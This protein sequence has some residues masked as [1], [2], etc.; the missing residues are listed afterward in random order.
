[1][2]QAAHRKLHQGSPFSRPNFQPP[3]RDLP[4]L[5]EAT[6]GEGEEEEE[7]EEE[8]WLRS[9]QRA[10]LALSRYLGL[11]LEA[12]RDLNPSQASLLDELAFWATNTRG[13]AADM[14]RLLS[15]LGQRA[16]PE[17]QPSPAPLPAMAASNWEK[18]LLGLEI[19]AR[20]DRWLQG[21]R[22]KFARLLLKYSLCPRPARC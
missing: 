16:P 2:L 19:C 9:S 13:L 22:K 21:S 20:C 6:H 4:G 15:G 17:A 14:S 12:Q 18:K 5:P 3:S 1:M 8:S 11:V 10:Y 7:E